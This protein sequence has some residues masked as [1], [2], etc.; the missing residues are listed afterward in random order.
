MNDTDYHLS[1]RSCQTTAH[2]PPDFGES[3]LPLIMG[4][5]A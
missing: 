4:A 5:G 2:Q 3:Q 1:L